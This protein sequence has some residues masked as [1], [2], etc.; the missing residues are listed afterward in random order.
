MYVVHVQIS[1]PVVARLWLRSNGI[2]Q[3]QR[4]LTEQEQ[5][6][7][8]K[9]GK[10]KKTNTKFLSVGRHTRFPVSAAVSAP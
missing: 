4:K 8:K 7:T 3:R 1:R 6:N 10:Q 5:D 9:A 2:N